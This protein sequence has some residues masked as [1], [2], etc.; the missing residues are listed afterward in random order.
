RRCLLFRTGRRGKARPSAAEGL[1]RSPAPAVAQRVN[2][3][4]SR[5]ERHFKS[6]REAPPALRLTAEEVSA[7]TLRLTQGARRE[8][9]RGREHLSCSSWHRRSTTPEESLS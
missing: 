7:S 4:D 1:S 6:V 9:K 5:N 3:R 8:K 2:E